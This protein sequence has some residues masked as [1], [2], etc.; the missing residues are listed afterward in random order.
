MLLGSAVAW[1]TAGLFV[2][3]IHLDAM[4]MVVW[5]GPAGALGV[6]AAIALV[7]RGR[8]WAAFKAMRG[9]AWA[10]A[11]ISGVDMLIYVAS[12]R[13]TTVA[14]VAFIYATVPF[15]AAGL[16][17]LFLGEHPSRS[18]LVA[19][20]VA[21]I[22]VGIM[23]ANPDLGSSVLGD[24]LALAVMVFT[25]GL[26]VISRRYPGIPMLPAASMSGLV[27]GLL[28]LPLATQMP[29][30]A[31]EFALISLSGLVNMALGLGLLVVGARLLPAVETALIGTLEG[32]LGPLWVWLAFG[33]AP[34]WQTLCGGTLVM[35]AVLG[36]LLLSARSRAA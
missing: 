7:E 26:M 31:S 15:A 2:R 36:H 30:S 28:A 11:I 20:A 5:R 4:S 33:E 3:L 19:C 1:S 18:A 9:A 17:Y 24:L 34:G 13:L 27:A 29:G 32:P 21:L 14:H 12:L 6:L 25:A 23:V 35:L 22:G 8:T 10:Y 16:G